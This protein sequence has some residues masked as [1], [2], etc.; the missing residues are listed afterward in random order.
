MCARREERTGAAMVGINKHDGV[1]SAAKTG[2]SGV[3]KGGAHGP[4]AEESKPHGDG[5]TESGANPPARRRIEPLPP[6]SR[7]Q[8]RG[9]VVN[10]AVGLPMGGDVGPMQLRNV[11]VGS[12]DA[13]KPM[14]GPEVIV[15]SSSSRSSTS[16][17]AEKE[18]ATR[19]AGWQSNTTPESSM[20]QPGASISV[21]SGLYRKLPK[22]VVEKV[23]KVQ[24]FRDSVDVRR[25]RAVENRQ[26]QA[27][28]KEKE[29]QEE[30]SRCEEEEARRAAAEEERRR[31][32]Q[33]SKIALE[34]QQRIR[35][36]ELEVEAQHRALP[37]PE[38]SSP[39]SFARRMG[40]SSRII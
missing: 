23:A 11:S 13:I 25:T 16:S 17:S 5:A 12:F 34:E 22:E 19:E 24:N 27:A 31:K 6:Q 36:L 32:L 28:A 4:T 10:A 30:S 33:A 29:Q 14:S 8:T 39:A 21:D 26:R 7:T 18:H 37:P 1:V 38:R 2:K 3:Q 20:N 40:F 15:M 9:E 35:D